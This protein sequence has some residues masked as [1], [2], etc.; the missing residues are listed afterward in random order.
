M[1][2]F[3][4]LIP[5]DTIYTGYTHKVVHKA[6]EM[7]VINRIDFWHKWYIPRNDDTRV[8]PGN[9]YKWVQFSFWDNTNILRSHALAAVVIFTQ[10]G[11]LRLHLSGGS[12][13]SVPVSKVTPIIPRWFWR[14]LFHSELLGCFR[15]AQHASDVSRCIDMWQITTFLRRKRNLLHNKSSYAKKYFE[16]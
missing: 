12:L 5:G 10:F 1:Y 11:T 14:T 3:T 15:H 9:D 16:R 4:T 6:A 2:N 8:N 13:A 7:F